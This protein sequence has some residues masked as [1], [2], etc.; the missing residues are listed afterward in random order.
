MPS[1]FVVCVPPDLV[2]F[3]L[4]LAHSPLLVCVA[5]KAAC[6]SLPPV[7]VVGWSHCDLGG[8]RGTGHFYT[9]LQICKLT[10]HWCLLGLFCGECDALLLLCILDC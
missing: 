8:T 1:C 3:F 6:R 9:C 7:V 10:Y 5:E 4:L 2:L